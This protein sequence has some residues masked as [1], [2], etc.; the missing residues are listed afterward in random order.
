[1]SY[2]IINE[3]YLNVTPA[4]AYYCMS[5]AESDL[6]RNVLIKLL[7]LTT[8]MQASQ[9]GFEDWFGS[10]SEQG[11]ATLHH[12]QKLNWL[13]SSEEKLSCSS[14][15]L[16]QVLPSLLGD[17][18]SQQK[19]LLA[20]SQGFYLSSVGFQHES[21]EEL[22]ALSAELISLQER[23][24]GLLNRN[25]KFSSSSWGIINVAGH[26]Q[27]GFWPLHVGKELFSLVIGGRPLLQHQSFLHLAWVLH[28]RYAV[29]QNPNKR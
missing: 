2:E 7:T 5:S 8:T 10:D 9:K 27:L 12:L 16:E 29:V 18:S 23:H 15:K 17:L 26:S 22:S 25:L 6:A 14:D 1:M 11:I 3:R 24:S 13:T 21:A 19:V 4:G 28:T 20:D